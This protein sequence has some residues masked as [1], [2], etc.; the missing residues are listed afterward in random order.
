[1]TRYFFHIST[2][3]ETLRDDE[4]SE[5]PDLDAA[6]KVALRSA[7]QIMSQNVLVG[8]PSNGR[9]FVITDEGGTVVFEFPFSDALKGE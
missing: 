1:V 5:L 4:G 9:T 3:D 7:R 6:K 2:G 8:R